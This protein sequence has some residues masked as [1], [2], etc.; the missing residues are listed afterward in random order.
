[1]AALSLASA[2]ITYVAT[3]RDSLAG[4]LFA[5]SSQQWAEEQQAEQQ[6]DAQIAQDTVLTSKLDGLFSA[7][8]S[9]LRAAEAVE[10]INPERAGELRLRAQEAWAQYAQLAPLLRAA[11]PKP[12][13]DRLVYDPVHAKNLARALDPKS[14]RV[15]SEHTRRE[16]RAAAELTSWTVLAVLVLVL[17]LFLLTIAH[18]IGRRRGTALAWFAAALSAGAVVWFAIPDVGAAT[19]VLG[20]AGGVGL[21]LLVARIPAARRRL[22]GLADGH[23]L[24]DLGA[25]PGPPDGMAHT[26]P[27]HPPSSRFDQS[28]VLTIAFATLLGAAVGYMQGQASR[29]AQDSAWAAN[30]RGVQAI[31]ALRTAEEDAAVQLDTFAEALTQRAGAWNASQRAAL[32]DSTGDS[33]ASSRW[34]AEATRLTALG[35]RLSERSQLGGRLGSAGI[36]DM[37]GLV[38]I[39]AAVWAK[40]AT[41]VG[42]QDAFNAAAASWSDRARHYLAVLS[43]LAVAVY[44]LGLSLV[45]RDWMTRR[46][47]ALIGAALIA[48]SLGISGATILSPSPVS[49]ARAA[50]AASAYGEGVVAAQRNDPETAVEH[51]TRALKERPDFGLASGE[52]AAATLMLGSASGLGFRAGFTQDAVN[53]AIADLEA[54][55]AR[56]ANTAWVRLNL[57]AMLIH[58]SINNGS[59]A[60]MAHSIDESRA[61]LILGGDYDRH[62]GPYHANQILG[63]INLGL[64]LLASGRPEEAEREYR[65]IGDQI[66]TL[67]PYLQPYFVTTGTSTLDL[68]RK[69]PRPV[70][71]EKITK[72]KSLLAT[73]VYPHPDQSPAAVTGVSAEVY[74]SLLQWRA[75][76]DQ[77]DTKRD[78]LAVHWYRLDPTIGE[79]GPV[80]V[81]S[82]ALVLGGVGFGGQ[83]MSDGPDSYWGNS[84]AVLTIENPP[85]CVRPG[86]Y[87]VELYLNGTLAGTDEADSPQEQSAYRP[88]ISRDLGAA[89]CTLDGWTVKQTP[90]DSR[91]TR[92]ADGNRGLVL[93]RVQQPLIPGEDARARA[94]DRTVARGH[95]LPPGLT[96]DPPA[97]GKMPS[98]FGGRQA[99]WRTYS[100]PGGTARTAA[101]FLPSG[102]VLVACAFGDH[103]WPSTPEAWALLE[104]TT[105]LT[106]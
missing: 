74:P 15:S 102:A 45:F 69:A 52:R 92:S 105:T 31:G 88:V 99:V 97:Y 26:D 71:V 42:E 77:F 9:N 100:Y 54:A 6:V 43:W 7:Y 93:F 13:G 106:P 94:I 80:P 23:N 35:E 75:T 29:A 70:P 57:G 103:T 64:A 18:V 47:L 62:G 78:S 91:A 95:E 25:V 32:A 48:L 73:T 90:G 72:M 28:V 55:T 85:T 65:L 38:A 22:S 12:D 19:P 83:F 30:D 1:M 66:R 16:A 76:I 59:E 33:A 68:V 56:G 79:W 61:G 36:E 2:F 4:D 50:S 60:D 11:A 49:M 14:F 24:A 58:R 87:R 51:F 37:G 81:A 104:S 3:E 39:R 17:S 63:R 96:P 34:S 21:L 89:M 40:P 84:S 67:P 86:K 98:V 44:L 82:G 27:S 20:L 41:L 53:R 5:I 10:A 101:V 8:V 46:L